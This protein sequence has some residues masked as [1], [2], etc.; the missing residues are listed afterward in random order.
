M[1]RS[2]IDAIGF[3]DIRSMI[4]LNKNGHLYCE[5]GRK[6]QV[7]ARAIFVQGSLYKV[8]ISNKI[9]DKIIYILI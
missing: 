1:P 7:P 2:E 4:N 3:S 6:E 8:T 9:H 5:M